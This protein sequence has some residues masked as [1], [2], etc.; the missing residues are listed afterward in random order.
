VYTLGC[1]ILIKI[2]LALSILICS[3]NSY[4]SLFG[5]MELSSEKC[6][7]DSEKEL[8]LEDEEEEEE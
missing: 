3:G 6:H 2:V 8:Q 5:R 4:T 7:F 1:S